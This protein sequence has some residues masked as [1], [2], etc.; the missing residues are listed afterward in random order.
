MSGRSVALVACA[1]TACVSAAIIV[2]VV[3]EEIDKARGYGGGR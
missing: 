3:I 2:A 1:V